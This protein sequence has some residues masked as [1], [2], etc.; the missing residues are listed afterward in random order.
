MNV[1]RCTLKV[2]FDIYDNEMDCDE[3]VA[4]LVDAADHMGYALHDCVLES[5]EDA[6]VDV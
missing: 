1:K 4:I 5:V 6:E 3:V 2:E